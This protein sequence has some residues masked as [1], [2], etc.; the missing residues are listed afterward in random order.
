M[1]ISKKDVGKLKIFLIMVIFFLSFQTAC[2][3]FFNLTH[4]CQEKKCIAGQEINWTFTFKNMGS[5]ELKLVDI[6]VVE[7]VNQSEIAGIHFEYDVSDS[8]KR[9]YFPVPPLK[10]KQLIINDKIPE[11]NAKNKLVYMPCITTALPSSAAKYLDD[12]Y[13]EEKCY[14]NK[15]I[16]VFECFYDRHCGNDEKCMARKCVEIECDYC[17]YIK[18]RECIEY[19]CCKT[20]ECNKGELCINHKCTSLNCSEDEKVVNNTCVKLNCS[21]DEYVSEHECINLE[22]DEG[23]KPFNHTCIKLECEDDEH[24]FEHECIKLD[25]MNEEYAF[26]H[27]C[28]KLECEEGKKPLNHTCVWIECGFFEER[29]GDEC[30][31]DGEFAL[32]F[33]AEILITIII[34][35]FFII[36]IKKYRKEKIKRI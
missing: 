23:K 6:E 4:E 28:V 15:S 3:H 34:I 30:I 21:Y 9:D 26:N 2:A 16:D 11:Q 12:T 19:E 1:T 24:I 10:Q 18:N 5:N 17:Q 22:C 13:V 14:A 29:K 7:S 25:C 33:L 20:E 27:T 8:S 36:D 32:K 35:F 31:F